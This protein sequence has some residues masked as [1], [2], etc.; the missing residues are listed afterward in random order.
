MR[1]IVD[2]I[3]VKVLI[4]LIFGLYSMITHTPYESYT[5]F[6]LPWK[7]GAVL[8]FGKWFNLS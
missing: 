7:Y 2:C 8:F 6:P 5:L 1:C 4:P 3:P